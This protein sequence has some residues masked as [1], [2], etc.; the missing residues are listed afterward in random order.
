MHK[1]DLTSRNE[2]ETTA[3]YGVNKVGS[4]VCVTALHTLYRHWRC[5]SDIWHWLPRG[6]HKICGIKSFCHRTY[7]FE[8]VLRVPE[9]MTIAKS[10]GIA[11]AYQRWVKLH[12]SMHRVLNLIGPLSIRM[13]TKLLYSVRESRTVIYFQLPM[14]V[15]GQYRKKRQE[16]SSIRKHAPRTPKLRFV[17]HSEVRKTLQRTDR[18][19]PHLNF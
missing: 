1:Q 2:L 18:H 12:G 4:P 9:I 10:L 17:R 14:K 5:L 3:E 15:T 13:I 6:A 16:V 19:C 8:L 11:R 7:R